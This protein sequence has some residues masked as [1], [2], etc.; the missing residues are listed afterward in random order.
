MEVSL[1]LYDGLQDSKGIG[2][3]YLLAH[4]ITGI[5]DVAV[6][7]LLLYQLFELLIVVGKRVS[8][9]RVC[10]GNNHQLVG[11]YAGSKTLCGGT[12]GSQGSAHNGCQ[13]STF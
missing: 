11:I 2:R 7:V 6:Y 8:T 9:E 13:G 10:I 3:F 12:L 1:A 4:E 5:D